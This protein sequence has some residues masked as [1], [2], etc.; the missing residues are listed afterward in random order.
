MTVLIAGIGN[1]FLGDDG[2]G[3][4]VARRLESVDLP[5][6]VEAGDY[7]IGGV[8]L[9]YDVLDRPCSCLVLVDAVGRGEAPGTLFVIEPDVEGDPATVA[10]AHGLGPAAVL[11]LL[12]TLEAMPERVLV[13]GCEPATVEPGMELSAPVAAGVDRAVELVRSLAAEEAARPVTAG[14]T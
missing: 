4:E 1:V 10:D 7:G 14:R 12:R 2:F 13:V 8:H 5:D 6:G 3:V 11:G 9:A